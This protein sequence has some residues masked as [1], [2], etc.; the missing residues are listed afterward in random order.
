MGITLDIYRARIGLHNY[1]K[2]KAT[3]LQ[4]T[5]NYR[6]GSSILIEFCGLASA[7]RMCIKYVLSF[8]CILSFILECFLEG[9]HSHT[10]SNINIFTTVFPNYRYNKISLIEPRIIVS[11]IMFCL[12][13]TL[14]V[15]VHNLFTYGFKNC[16]NVLYSRLFYKK[17]KCG[18]II[19][20]YSIWL[21]AMNLL[22]IILT[23][24]NILHSGPI[25]D[26][27]VLYQNVQS[28]VN[29]RAKSPSPCLLTS[30]VLNFQG[31][32]FHEK[33]DIVILNETWLKE[34]ILDSEIFPNNAY[35]VFR[36]SVEIDH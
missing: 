4:K 26:L 36:S 19:N 3:G 9:H 7:A 27:N 6:C 18:C 2:C 11:C 32:L 20:L 15:L 30:K 21:F 35:K 23:I 24:P 5:Q 31:Y 10:I 14:P 17:S 29:I 16:L 13:Y 12:L 28:F 22:L 1:Y 33:P 8:L 34:P 25:N